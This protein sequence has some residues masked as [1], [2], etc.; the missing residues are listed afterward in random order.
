MKFTKKNLGI[1]V[2]KKFIY[3]VKKFVCSVILV[4]LF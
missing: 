2:V 4:S 3:V 1:Y